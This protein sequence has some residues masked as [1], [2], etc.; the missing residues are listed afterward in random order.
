VRK[1]SSQ[2]CLLLSMVHV[3]YDERRCQ[4][5]RLFGWE[6][7]SLM[8]RFGLFCRSGR[9]IGSVRRRLLQLADLFFHLL[10]WLEGYDPFLSDIDPF[11][12]AWVSSLTSGPLLNFKHSE[13]A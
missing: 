8:C 2:P 11:A 3:R 1:L 13:I 4:L 6:K 7:L 10:A 9:R 12:G 5:D